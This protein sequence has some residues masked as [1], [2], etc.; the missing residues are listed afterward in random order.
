MRRI[1]QLQG[2][3]KKRERESI[4][5]CLFILKLLDSSNLRNKINLKE[6]NKMKNAKPG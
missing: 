1:I 3:K 2:K 5:C 4:A 6:C